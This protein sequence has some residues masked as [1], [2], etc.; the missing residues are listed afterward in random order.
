MDRAVAERIMLLHRR[1]IR[2]R[3]CLVVVG[4]TCGAP[5]YPCGVRTAVL[6][7]SSPSAAESSPQ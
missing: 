3:S 5:R 7:G 4:C 2:V 1:T 6:T